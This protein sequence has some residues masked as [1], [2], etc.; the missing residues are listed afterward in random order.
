MIIAACNDDQ[1]VLDIASAASAATFGKW[2]KIFASSIPD[3][4]IDENLYIIAHGAAVGDEGQPVIGDKADAFYLTGR[5]L[6]SNLHIFPSGY[7]GGVFIYACESAKSGTTA[8]FVGDFLGVIHP[9]YP[10]ITVFGQ[11][12]KPS[13][14]LPG[15]SDSSWTKA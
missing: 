4:G 7:R 9:S 3:L 13:G 5:D 10:A 12:G 6:N 14:P 8:S 1:M 2:Y 15:P 11:T